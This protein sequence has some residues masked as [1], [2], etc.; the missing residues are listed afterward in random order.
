MRREGD[1]Q[2]GRRTISGW[3]GVLAVAVCSVSL[4][5]ADESSTGTNGHGAGGTGAAGGA[6]A[7]GGTGGAG[8]TCQHGPSTTGSLGPIGKVSSLAG[9][10]SN[11]CA[12]FEGGSIRCWGDN[13]Y[14]QIGSGD[15]VGGIYPTA[16]DGLPPVQ[17]V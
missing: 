8:D 14:G 7:G 16:P 9:G 15:L 17:R 4:G 11:V 3:C 2:A 6:G 13:A 5:C 10:T 12:L 1:K